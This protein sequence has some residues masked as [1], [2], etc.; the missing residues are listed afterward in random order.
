MIR[1]TYE[2]IVQGIDVRQ[3]VSL[4]RKQLKEENGKLALAYL[5]SGDFS[6]LENL[7][8]HDDAK[9]RKNTALLI[10]DLGDKRL[11]KPLFEA[12]E[13]ETTLFVRSSYL[14]A[15]KEFDCREYLFKLKEKMEQLSNLPLDETNKKH[16]LEETHALSELIVLMEGI[17]SHTFIGANLS[18][19]L[20]LLTNR[21]HIGITTKQL[22]E[23]G[24]EHIKEFGAGI[25]L[26]TKKLSEIS[27][28]RTIEEILFVVRGMRTCP[29]NA[30]LVAKQIVE[31]GFVTFLEERH[32]EKAPFYFR[33]ECKSKMPLDKKSV[34][35]RKMA[36]YLE[37]YSHRKLINSTSRYEVELRL[38]ENKD[39]NFN[40]LVKLATWKDMRFMY[41]KEVLSASIKPVNAALVVALAK[42]YL[43]EDGKV[44]D[45]FCGTG[46]MLIERHKQV[47]ANTSYGIDLF[48]D[49]IEKAKI[50]TEQ[51]HQIIHYINRD[52]FD[53]KHEYLFDEII[54]NMP[55]VT[56]KKSEKEIYQIYKQFFQKAREHLTE[57]GTIILYTHNL[58]MVKELAPKLKYTQKAQWEI[59]KREGTYV[60]VLKV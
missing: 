14:T 16:I 58:E 18:N 25:M 4:L 11:L 12:Y 28:I 30:E 32:K 9:T 37:Q 36:D 52:F 6:I 44:L 3:N 23:M 34:F 38:I 8:K 53:F 50:N 13:K 31:A 24:E 42:E 39:G 59:S 56:A 27:K 1:D 29:M 41:R 57:T 48:G 33:I 47:V 40:I 10:G 35:T 22:K 21:N 17:K 49:A 5:L 7:L 55:M 20:V 15:M 54:T 51:A 26:V 60:I 19:E 2:K 45:P 43:K 46:T